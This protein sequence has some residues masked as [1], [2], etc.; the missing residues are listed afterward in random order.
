MNKIILIVVIILLVGI[1]GYFFLKGGYQTP[2]PTSAPTSSPTPAPGVNPETVEE[3]IVSG[4]K[5]ITIISTEFNFNP[6]AVTVEAGEEVRIV[7]ENAGKTSHNLV[8]EGLEVKTKTI[9]GGQ[10]D[11]IE[12]TVTNSGTYTF[13]CSIP[14]HR[15]AGME[16]NLKVE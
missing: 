6:S 3:K 9:S 14:G 11:T 4:I 13:F 16:G 2:T 1:G 7:F 15:V 12:F 10:T 5:E 8:I